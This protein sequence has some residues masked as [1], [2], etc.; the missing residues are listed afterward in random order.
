M[1]NG[2]YETTPCK[3]YLID[4]ML[5]SIKKQRILHPTGF[6]TPL[7]PISNAPIAGC[8]LLNPTTTDVPPFAHPLVL[9]EDDKTTSVYT[10]VRNFTR[11]SR[12]GQVVVSA[13]LDYDLAVLRTWLQRVWL[14]YSPRDLLGLGTFPI[15]VYSRWVT[16]ALTRRMA[17]PPDVQMRTS[18]LTAY[19]YVC[20]FHDAAL[21]EN[22]DEKDKL[23]MAQMVSRATNINAAEV[24]SVIEPLPIYKDAAELIAGLIEH[25]NSMRYQ[26]LNLALLYSVVSGTWFG[27]NHR[28][29]V[30]VAVEHPVTFMAM[31]AKAINER[32]YHNTPIGKIVKMADRGDL[33]KTYIHNLLNLPTS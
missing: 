4:K 27:Q 5:A 11:V 30:A 28:E 20:M 26:D 6:D 24:I 29:L 25:G 15:T 2:A 9:V 7:A 8:Q 17:L 13:K 16:E 19:F 14:S 33:A 12:E 31:V 32:G 21:A 18:I 1:F 22:V 3:D 10:D 23:R